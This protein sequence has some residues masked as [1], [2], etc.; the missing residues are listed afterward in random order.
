MNYQLEME[1]II[2]QNQGIKTLLLH[3]CC[4]PCSSAVLERLAPFFKITVLYYNPNIAPQAEYE[5][6]KQEQISFL[7]KLALK[8]QISWMD[9]DYENDKYEQ[10]IEGLK[11]EPEGGSR[12]FICYQLRLAKT[13]LLAKKNNFDFF[14]TTLT[15]SPYKNAKKINEI[16]KELQDQT[17]VRYLPSDFK[18]K[19]GYLR[20]IELSKQYNLYRQNYCG[21]LYSKGEKYEN[22]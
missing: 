21:C 12:C 7:Q 6:R 17:G 11:N 13:A 9:V 3:S 22:N 1:N 2:K 5:K 19:N 4:A 8:Y 15:V 18:K 16:G 10:A 14:A 20:S